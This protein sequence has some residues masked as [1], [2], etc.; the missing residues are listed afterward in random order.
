MQSQQTAKT[1]E[2]R[3]AG[4]EAELVEHQQRVGVKHSPVCSSGSHILKPAA[5][6]H[7]PAM[8]QG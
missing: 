8:Y 2:R 3:L 6:S 1:L 4:M 7:T 5:V